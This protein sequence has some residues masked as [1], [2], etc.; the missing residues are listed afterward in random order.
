MMNQCFNVVCLLGYDAKF[1]DKDN[2]DSAQT[3]GLCGLL[4]FS[5]GVDVRWYVFSGCSSCILPYF[6]Y[7]NL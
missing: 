5:L 1:F 7:T 4:E 6:P 3:D 2:E